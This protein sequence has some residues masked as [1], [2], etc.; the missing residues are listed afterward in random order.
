LL[1]AD[2]RAQ[3]RDDDKF[4]ADLSDIATELANGDRSGLKE[5]LNYLLNDVAK[6]EIET[7]GR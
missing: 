3:H 1:L 7:L 6:E 4:S 2:A 5:T